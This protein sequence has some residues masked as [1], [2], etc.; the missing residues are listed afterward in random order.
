[1]ALDFPV[2]GRF[3]RGLQIRFT[4]PALDVYDVVTVN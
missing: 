1:M 3:Y 4:L 2:L